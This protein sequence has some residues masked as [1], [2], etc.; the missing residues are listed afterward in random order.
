MDPIKK[1]VC[2]LCIS[3]SYLIYINRVRIKYLKID[4]K[5]KG[6]QPFLL[7]YDLHPRWALPSI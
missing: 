6:D 2:R 4:N 1:Y 3:S 7:S 5:I